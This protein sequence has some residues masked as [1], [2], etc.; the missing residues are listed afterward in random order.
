V[1]GDAT[2]QNKFAGMTPRNFNPMLA[3]GFRMK[4]RKAVNAAFDARWHSSHSRT[5]YG[6]E[7]RGEINSRA[8]NPSVLEKGA[9]GGSQ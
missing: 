3:P 1:R 2:I 9:T 4:A 6:E 7:F 5:V 8:G